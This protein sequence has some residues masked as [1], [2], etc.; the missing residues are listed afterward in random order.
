MSVM[1][2]SPQPVTSVSRLAARWLAAGVVALAALAVLAAPASAHNA[3]RSVTPADGS[4][5]EVA[6]ETVD[7]V[8]DEPAIALGTQI[9]VLGPDSNS[10]S[11]G[12][13]I[14]VDSAVSQPLAAERPAGT[15]TVQWR[16]TSADGHPISGQFTFSASSAAGVPAATPPS[17]TP[18][19]ETPPSATSAVE[20]PAPAP[21][22]DATPAAEADAGG[23]ANGVA[24]WAIA[25]GA[26]VVVLLAAGAIWWVRRAQS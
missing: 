2:S 4:T 18:P 6:P 8:F 13:P 26:A 5:V 16:V 10:V 24:P 17:A 11:A 1:S 21:S 3:L 7:L 14:L 19:V 25:A 12:E 22:D 15:Y 20:T 9:L 23:S